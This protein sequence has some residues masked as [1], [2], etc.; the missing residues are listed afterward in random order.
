MTSLRIKATARFLCICEKV[1][2]KTTFDYSAELWIGNED[3]GHVL[4]KLDTNENLCDTSL[5]QFSF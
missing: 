2:E 4:K 1:R 3:V 5:L